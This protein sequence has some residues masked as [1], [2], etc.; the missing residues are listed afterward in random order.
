MLR[1]QKQYDTHAFLVSREIHNQMG[2]ASNLNQWSGFNKPT[3]KPSLSPKPVSHP[4]ISQ[5]FR[6]PSNKAIAAGFCEKIL[7]AVLVG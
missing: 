1:R 3:T 7:P 2:G 5:Q 4:A 6:L